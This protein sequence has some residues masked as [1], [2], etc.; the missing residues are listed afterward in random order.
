[1]KTVLHTSYHIALHFRREWLASRDQLRSLLVWDSTLHCV[2]Q[3][4]T[5]GCRA[6]VAS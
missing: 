3:S 2:R 4:V 1:M 6:R 5:A